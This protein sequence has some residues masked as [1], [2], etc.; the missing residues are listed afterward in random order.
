MNHSEHKIS[1]SVL[2][3]TVHRCRGVG[4]SVLVFAS[5]LK[6]ALRIK[7]LKPDYLCVEPPELVG[8]SKSV[9]SKS[10][11]VLN[12]KKKLGC[13]FLVGAGVHSREDVVSALGD[14]AVGVA[15]S[16]GVVNARSP[17]KVLGDLVKRK[18]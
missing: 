17:G 16:S 8:G 6:E 4:L 18:V 10:G 3:K 9:S 15:V 13:D 7:K 2:S 14:G 12:L 1:F 5:S 11:Y